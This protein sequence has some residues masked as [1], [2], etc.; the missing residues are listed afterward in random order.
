MRT[1]KVL[2]WEIAGMFFIIIIGSLLHFTYELSGFWKPASLISA[3]NESTWEHLKI[4]FWPA[5]IFL[6][7]EFFVLR[8]ETKN[9]IL[10]KTV[11]LYLIPIVI[12]GLFYS[13]TAILGRDV[14]FLDISIFI[15]SI[16]VAQIVS[17]RLM[18]LKNAHITANQIAIIFLIIEI[19]AFS[20]LS[21]FPPHF[22]LFKDPVT[23][24][25]GLTRYVLFLKIT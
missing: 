4:G 14:F 16:V 17:Y 18:L 23:G 5:L 20:F 19:M 1:K 10:A 15:I 25:Y 13:Y 12:T 21:Y 9:F 7:I 22:F 3:V 2:A 24:G 8:K 6:I 11:S